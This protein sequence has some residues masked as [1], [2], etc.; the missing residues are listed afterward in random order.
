MIFQTIQARHAAKH[1]DKISNVRCFS[2]DNSFSGQPVE[3]QAHAIDFALNRMGGKLQIAKAE[4]QG[5]IRLHSN[6]WYEFEY[7]G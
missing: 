7:R 5:K 2:L 3:D 4:G 6:L 1:L